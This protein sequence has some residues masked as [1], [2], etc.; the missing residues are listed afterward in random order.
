MKS[1]TKRSGTRA[2][3]AATWAAMG[4][5]A[6]LVFASGAAASPKDSLRGAVRVQP[7]GA[8]DTA[9]LV[10]S[11][12]NHAAAPAR[13]IGKNPDIYVDPNLVRQLT[14]GG[15]QDFAIEFK[16][17]P[18]LSAAYSMDWKARGR[19]VH[20]QLQQA[21]ER[22]Q[23][24]VA[25]VLNRRGER[26]QSFVVKNVI[27]VRGGSYQTMESV[28]SF[29][30]IKSVRIPPRMGLIL[31]ERF[32]AP[33]SKTPKAADSNRPKVLGTNLDWVQAD[34]VWAQG[35][36]GTGA[37][38][39]VIDS[40]VRYDHE[41][42]VTQYRGN[43][44]GSFDHNYSWLDPE[45][46][47]P[48]PAPASNALD[49]QH[50]TH[51][52]GT[53]VGD[54][55]DANEATRDRVGMAPG[56]KWIA[57]QGFPA[58]GS[59]DAALLGCGDFMLAPTDLSGSNPDPDRRPMAVNNS[60]GDCDPGTADTYYRDVVDSWNAAGVIPVF[61]AGN[62][63]NCG[64]SSPPGLATVGSPGSYADVF[65]IGSTGNSN[66]LYAPHSNWGPTNA[67]NLGLPDFPDANGYPQ[68]KPN[69]VAP[70]VNIRSTI[71]TGTTTYDQAGWTGT[72]MS[73]PHVVGLMALM[74]DA[75]DCLVGEYGTVGTLIQQTARPIDYAS[76]TTGGAA[77]P[78]VGNFPNYATGW[79]EIDA[80][81]AVTAAI[82]ECGDQGFVSGTV[83][84][85]GSGTP[86]A[87]ALV[88]IF[89]DENVRIYATTTDAQGVYTRRV[90]VTVAP[91]TYTVRVSRYGFLGASASGVTVALEQTT[92]QDFVLDVADQYTVSG[93]VRDSATGWP[94]HARIAIA[95]Y[96]DSP[97]WSDP[98]TGAYSV[99]LAEGI[100]YAFTVTASIPGYTVDTADIGPLAANTAQDFAL[101][102]DLAACTA[103]GY[104]L[105]SPLLTENF[106][107]AGP[108]ETPPIG[109]TASTL[110][111]GTTPGWRFGTSLGSAFHPI[112]PHTRYAAT[113]DDDNN[114]NGTQDYLISPVFDLSAA[115]NS[116]LRFDSRL[117]GEYGTTGEVQGS[118]DGGTTWTVVI[119]SP[120]AEGEAGGWSTQTMSLAGLGGS[121]QAR[122]R[123]HSN[124]NG[125]WADGWAVDDISVVP[126]CI[127]PASG[128]LVTG[129]VVDENTGEGLNGARVEVDGGATVITFATADPSIGDGFYAVFAAPGSADVDASAGPSLP[130]GYGTDSATVA[131]VDE[132]NTL[133]DL[134]L[135][136]ARLAVTPA[137]GPT[138]TLPL[139]Q[140]QATGFSLS[141]QGSLPADYALVS[142]G[143]VEDFEDA[144]PPAGWSVIDD[145]SDC[146]WDT[147]ANYGLPNHAG[148]DGL[149][150]TVSSDACGLGTTA[151]TSL[152]SPVFSLAFSTQASLDFVL[153][154]RHLGSSRFDVDISTDGGQNWT[155]LFAQTSSTSASGPGTPIQ[156]DLVDYLGAQQARL[157]L[158]YRSGWDYWVL[159]DQIRLFADANSIAWL[160]ISPTAGSLG[161][162][163]SSQSHT[164]VFR[165][166]Q[167]E[168]PG[169][170]QARLRVVESTPY[171]PPTLDATMN[172]TAP[173]SFGTVSGTV[174]GLG[175]C[176]ADPAPIAGA[177][178][179]IQG[180][181]QV[182][183]T[184]TDANGDYSWQLDAG[185]S[186]LTISASAIGH[187]TAATTGIALAAGGTSTAD[188]AL[189][190]ALPCF[191]VVQ[192]NLA[193]TL[194]SGDSD[195]RALTL[196]NTG[197][198]GVDP[199]LIE[200][201]GD[202]EVRAAVTLSQSASDT[203]LAG[204]AVACGGGGTTADN[205]FLRV[206][207]PSK[208]GYFG[209][210]TIQNV[211]FKVEEAEAASGGAQPVITAVYALDGPLEGLALDLLG[212]ATVNV[213]D[214]S[215][216]T[217][218]ATFDPPISVPADTQLLVELFSDD[219]GHAFYPGTNDAGESAPSYVFSQACSL[220][221]PVAFADIGFPDVHLILDLGVEGARVCGPAATPVDWLSATP[222]VTGSIAAGGSATVDAVFDADGKAV[223]QYTGAFCVTAADPVAGLVV[224]PAAMDVVAAVPD[225]DLSISVLESAD[226]VQAGTDLDYAI[227]VA[228][229]GPDAATGVELAIALPNALAYEGFVGTD[230][231]CSE[232]AGAVSC[233]YASTVGATGAAAAL[234]VRTTPLLAG[235]AV[236]QF[237]VSG[238]GND[239][240]ST[241]D[242]MSV[243]TT[244]TP[245]PDVDLALMANLDPASVVQGGN[246]QLELVSINVGSDPATGVE[247]AITLP[248]N[249]GYV[250]AI[251]SGWT[252]A[253]AGSDVVCELATAVAAGFAPA[254]ELTLS[255][256]PG[257]GTVQ[258]EAAIASNEADANAGNNAASVELVIAPA[259]EQ[260]FD[261]GFE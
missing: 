151:D 57:C 168:Q 32:A 145:G 64:Y 27:L 138:A 158:R 47:S 256:G 240:L 87:G 249:V 11:R 63:S 96:P 76:G 51:V 245:A 206:Y 195:T 193:A 210:V 149:A 38:V 182:Y 253:V 121:A 61:A 119:G 70:G 215:G 216:G 141:N 154:Y 242:V 251:G 50:G 183:Q 14:A 28:L 109:W 42:L 167:V 41:A 227:T 230:W 123:F 127:T 104:V 155:N 261:D 117:S 131:V 209:E 165:A 6:C 68:L 12:S 93:F 140:T 48:F 152:I 73:T 81:D 175:Y 179:F 102:P 188:V 125:S 161:V 187:V 258:I 59:V 71:G 243:T 208:E 111:I 24:R 137:G 211:R 260:I 72:S 26:F 94:L 214:G 200:V 144:F 205:S 191:D 204:N 135:P 180:G 213:T 88:E 174:T 255:A 178:V 45:G 257:F 248:A 203:V 232:A 112:P 252:C 44:G 166:N 77:A 124:D 53:I 221:P 2:S 199:W 162:A 52:A 118:T 177:T 237:T 108:P 129:R 36:T 30:E 113:N 55:F 212:E 222:P 159:V 172:V 69:V 74:F 233:T 89:V 148:G 92:D 254:L 83:T 67:I 8:A 225:I 136:A 170:Y 160:G 99:E 9:A 126:G 185:Q 139:G 75:A 20:R 105:A 66:G 3:R 122:L 37:V 49:D 201:G 128:G 194:E 143:L 5:V 101:D 40:G 116:V 130:Q 65:T 58:S 133:L 19:F 147:N 259:G 46:N 13:G 110:A 23:A 246:V 196:A 181:S 247:V 31:P 90:P 171:P 153:A 84:A 10:G 85:A 164:A 176:D 217:Y 223:G 86:V 107:A 142:A 207:T 184:T 163:P 238:T 62:A 39:G 120:P 103:P 173:A 106:E 239:V 115:P 56:A 224:V 231:S 97:V 98:V 169:S 16:E 82:E 79:G 150:A 33:D 241:N 25:E 202:P 192:S 91:D 132:Q 236:A 17:R 218:V 157:R 250:G 134:E 100:E 1:S 78:G 43:L 244:V 7:S 80:L 234:T 18:D 156:I 54:D 226:P 235:D 15:T 95:G 114:Q 189:R 198:V 229:A 220:V 146:P 34:E 190:A 228:N 197:A 219:A 29:E 35:Y 60:W 4:L 21:A 22:S 186:P